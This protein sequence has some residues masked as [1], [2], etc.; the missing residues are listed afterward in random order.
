MNCL[1]VLP[2]LEALEAKYP[3]VLT[4][5]GIHSAKFPNERQAA[6][7]HHAIHRHHI[8]HPVVND[9]EFA[10]W[11]RYSVRAWPTLVLIDPAGYVVAAVTGEGNGPTLDSRIG[12]LVAEHRAT[13]TL[14]A[15]P[16]PAVPTDDAG[17]APLAFPGKVAVEP[18]SGS[19][20]VADSGRHRV[21]VADLDG[22]VRAVVGTGKPGAA[23]GPFPDASFCH[24]QGLAFHAGGLYV[25]DTENHLIRRVDLVTRRVE[26][27]VGT[28]RQAHGPLR[29]PEDGPLAV[30]LNSPWDLVILNGILY[31]AMAGCHQVWGLDL[32]QGSLEHVC[33]TGREALVDGPRLEASMNQPSGITT[34]GS[35]LYVADSEASAIRSIDPRPGGWIRT[36]VGVGLFEFGDRDGGGGSVR[37]QHPLGVA[38]LNGRIYLADTYNH[39]IK[40]LFPSLQRVESLFGTGR[41]GSA[42]GLRAELFEPGGLAATPGRLFIADTNNHRV[43]VAD[44]AAETVTSLR[45]H[46]PGAA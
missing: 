13:G 28:G 20:A 21:L 12:E 42:E 30:D 39:K 7:L 3:Q 22:A 40:V 37:L 11:D 23:D 41:P 29:L 43:C 2:E 4:V 10:I 6:S 19:L 14:R 36:L 25:A 38:A 9:T 27:I 45:L 26:T 18:A 44:L 31:I 17:D 8:Q 35:L 1:H 46:P 33:G 15:G 24:P 5:V 16:R 32:T 34:D